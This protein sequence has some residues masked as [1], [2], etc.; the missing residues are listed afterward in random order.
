MSPISRSG[1]L[2]RTVEDAGMLMDA[3]VDPTQQQG[4]YLTAA[5]E[6]QES[7]GNLSI[8]YTTAAPFSPI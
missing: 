5:R 2:A 7:A 4:R 8:G 3:L 1:P 6:G